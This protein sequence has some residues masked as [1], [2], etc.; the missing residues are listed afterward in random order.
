MGWQHGWVIEYR[1]GQDRFCT[2]AEGRETWHSF[3]FGSHYDPA[4]VAFGPLVAFNDERLAPGAG[5]DPHHHGGIEIV[6]YVVAGTLSHRSDADA[7]RDATLVGAGGLQRLHAADGV[8]HSERNASGSQPLRFVQSWLLAGDPEARRHR[9]I[10]PQVSRGE[11]N[12]VAAGLSSVAPDVLPLSVVGASLAVGKLAPGERLPL[13]AG[14]THVFV[15]EGAARLTGPADDIVV[16]SADALRCSMSD[17][18]ELIAGPSGA[19]LLSWVFD[20]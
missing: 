4:N 7:S 13:P 11:W 6:T 12:V 10:T 19:H 17:A 18:G 15:V 9:V 1:L 5:F 8:V 16:E 3:S 14:R 20:D 2:E